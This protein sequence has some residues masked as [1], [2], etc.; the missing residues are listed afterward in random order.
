ME[1][2]KHYIAG[3]ESNT[4]NTFA[5]TPS[6]T[7]IELSQTG[8]LTNAR[9]R[10]DSF[11]RTE[12]ADDLEVHAVIVANAMRAVNSTSALTPIVA[13][14]TLAQTIRNDGKQTVAHLSG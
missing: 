10:R 4:R 1:L 6:A 3:A 2:S 7:P 5:L 11:N 8:K 12:F 13:P 9:T 14:N